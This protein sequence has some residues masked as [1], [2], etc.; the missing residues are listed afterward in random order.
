MVGSCTYDEV[1]GSIKA[2][3]AEAKSQQ[4][5]HEQSAA[6]ATTAKST[7]TTAAGHTTKK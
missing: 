4:K 2:L 7:A 1:E 5:E 6:Q 3:A